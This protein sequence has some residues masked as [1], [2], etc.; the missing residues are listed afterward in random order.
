M[1]DPAGCIEL[2]SLLAGGIGKLRN[3]VFVGG[4]E[5]IRE[6]EIFVQQ[7]IFVEVTDQT[8][9]PFVG[10]FRFT[11]LFSEIDVTEDAAEGLMVRVLQAGE[12]LVQLVGDAGVHIV[13]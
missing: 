4:P 1:D 9:Q 3:Q 12:S 10:D 5:Q 8:A 6:F 7:A 13:Q 2:T 11:D